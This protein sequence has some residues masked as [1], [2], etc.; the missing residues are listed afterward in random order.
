MAKT[1][2]EFIAEA[3][4]TPAI[5]GKKLLDATL[6]QNPEAKAFYDTFQIYIQTTSRQ[7]LY[8]AKSAITFE[9]KRPMDMKLKD[10]EKYIKKAGF[11]PTSKYDDWANKVYK[12]DQKFFCKIWGNIGGGT[13]GVEFGDYDEYS[14]WPALGT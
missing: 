1:Y 14:K 5:K 11:V 6:A 13:N 9:F 7:S 2:K 4:L 10:I 3:R 12:K 8:D